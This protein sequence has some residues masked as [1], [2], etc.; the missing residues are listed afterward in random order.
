MEQ[1][2]WVVSNLYTFSVAARLLSFT[3]AAEEL[4]LTQGAISQ[5][6]KQLESQLGFTLFI[7]MTRQLDLTDEGKRLADTVNASFSSIFSDIDDIKFNEL[8]GELYIGIAPTFAESWLMPRLSKFQA[9]YPNLNLKIRVKASPLDFKHEPVDLAI[10]YSHRQHSDMYNQILMP[11]T[12]TPVCTPEF[13]QRYQLSGNIEELDSVPI[14][15]CTESIDYADFDYEWQYWY[16]QHH[17]NYAKQKHY[18]VFNHSE[19]SISAIKNHMGIGMGRKSLIQPYL[20]RGELVT[21]FPEVSAGMSYILICPKGMEERP[22]FKAFT[23]WLTQQ[24]SSC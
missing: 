14:I 18:Y 9:L 10:Y 16:Q 17:L 11:E 7:R 21:L 5:R 22:R 2:Q 1:K 15:H 3:Q 23:H 6:I 20:D 8:G 19:T 24:I 12:L 13:A 4:N